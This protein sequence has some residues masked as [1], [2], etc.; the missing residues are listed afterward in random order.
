MGQ[1]KDNF[2]TYYEEVSDKLVDDDSIFKEQIDVIE[3]QFTRL[4]LTNEQLAQVMSQLMSASADFLNRYANGSTLDILKMEQQQ[5]L[6]DLQEEIAEQDVLLKKEQ[7]K[8]AE[9]ELE[10]KD[11]DLALK[12]KE[13]ELKD[14][15]IRLQDKNIALMDKQIAKVNQEIALM[16]SQTQTE[17]YKQQDLSAATNLKGAQAQTET[18]QA[19]LVSSQKALV[20]RQ[21]AGYGDNL[22]VKA[23]EFQ[24]GLAS[25]AV[26]SG[27]DDANAAIQ[28]FQST[29]DQIKGR[30]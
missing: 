30:A 6:L 15:E 14:K 21:T 28:A 27:S 9:K 25:F 19:S 29:I 12:Y 3:K 11:K 16:Q 13:L 5:P 20:D 4:G 24:G 8:L 2:I 18:N 10:I 17:N 7:V 22:Y 1:I 23:G 26:N